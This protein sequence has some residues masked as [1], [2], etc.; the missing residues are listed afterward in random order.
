MAVTAV[1]IS[2]TSTPSPPPA[3]AAQA[4]PAA[5]TAPVTEQYQ[6]DNGVFYKQVDGGY[7]AVPAPAGA[8]VSTIPKDAETVVVNETTT[9]FY[10]GGTYYEKSDKGYTVVPPTAGSVVS[11]LPEGGK[12]VKLGEQ[13]YVQVGDTFYQPTQKDGKDVY[14][15]A[16]VEA[17]TN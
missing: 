13:S 9:N 17:V 8:T 3:Q 5:P 14:E 16:Q 11:N 4:A 7:K 15:V 1:M 6:Y 12:E 2:V 10:Y